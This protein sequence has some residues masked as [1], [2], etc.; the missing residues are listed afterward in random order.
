MKILES[1][2]DGGERL[3]WARCGSDKTL[4]NREESVE[5]GTRTEAPGWGTAGEE[6]R[7]RVPPRPNGRGA[8][9]QERGRTPG[10]SGAGERTRSLGPPE[11]GMCGS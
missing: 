8:V 11:C 9:E 2:G 4:R 5:G 10:A 7:V 1:P 6:V 3:R